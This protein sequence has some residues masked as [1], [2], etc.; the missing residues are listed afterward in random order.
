MKSWIE[1]M[2]KCYLDANTLLYFTNPAAQF[3]ET[4]IELI[5]A[6]LIQNYALFISP[7]ILD[8]YFHNSIRFSQVP[9]RQALQDLKIGFGKIKKLKNINLVYS[10]LEFTKQTK[11]LNFMIKY[12]LRSRDAYHLFIMKE[13]KIK[14]LATFDD[15]FENVFKQ[16]LIKKFE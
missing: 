7:L 16:G 13:N 4:A 6:L 14:Y 1:D 5:S 3:H 12:Q 15:D 10:P 9:R 8:E 2:K 11:V